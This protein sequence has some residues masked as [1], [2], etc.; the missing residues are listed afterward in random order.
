MQLTPNLK[1]DSRLKQ[2]TQNV[3]GFYD[4]MIFF[5]FFENNLEKEKIR[6]S[7]F[8]IRIPGIMQC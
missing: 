2:E 5:G 6:I 8:L 7:K 3:F 4:F 1:F